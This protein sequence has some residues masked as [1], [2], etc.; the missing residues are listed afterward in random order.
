[1]LENL[2]ATKLH[3]PR[4]RRD[5]VPRP[6]LIEQLDNGLHRKL[7]IVSAPAGYGKTTTLTSWID[8]SQI[9]TAWLSID[10]A[11]N[12][13]DRFLTYLIAALQHLDDGI[14][15]DVQAALSE[16]RAASIETLL[17]RLINEVEA[18]MSEQEHRNQF[19]LVLDDYHLIDN[20]SVH[21]GVERLIDLCPPTVTIVVS[22]R[23]DPPFRL[24]GRS[25]ESRE[26]DGVRTRRFGLDS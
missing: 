16:S 8:Y 24:G 12:E 15:L 7:T 17:T 9:Q 18:V 21:R 14:G 23:V 19:I 22:T 1:M 20:A 11:D 26:R 5:M 3:I 10:E 25:D 6:R 2:L 13:L 4:S